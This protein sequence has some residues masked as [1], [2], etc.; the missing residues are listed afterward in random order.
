MSHKRPS[1]YDRRDADGRGTTIFS[2]G[3][4]GAKPNQQDTRNAGPRKLARNA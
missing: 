4:G 1:K 2:D 3:Y